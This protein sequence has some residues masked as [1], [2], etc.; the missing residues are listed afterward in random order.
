[1]N[2]SQRKAC[3]SEKFPNCPRFADLP[4]T[5]GGTCTADGHPTAQLIARKFQEGHPI[6]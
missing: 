3:L 1:M 6:I 2:R 4:D 5:N